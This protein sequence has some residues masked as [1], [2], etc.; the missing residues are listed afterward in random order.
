MLRTLATSLTAFSAYVAAAR[1]NAAE[2]P[3]P[4]SYSAKPV[5]G[6][7]E[8]EE[9]VLETGSICAANLDLHPLLVEK[10]KAAA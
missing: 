2:P 10:L 4:I 1:P 7:I 5:L 3:A 6:T 9:N 8:G